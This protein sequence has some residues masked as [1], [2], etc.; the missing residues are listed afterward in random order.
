ML[1]WDDARGPPPACP[2]IAI[3]S[4]PKI[5][6]LKD[7]PVLFISFYRSCFRKQERHRDR[8]LVSSL[9]AST[10]LTLCV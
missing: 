4:Y 5:Q 3:L 2:D 6:L 10:M 1:T 9:A 7:E 8:F